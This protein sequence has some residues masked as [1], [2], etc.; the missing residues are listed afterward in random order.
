MRR[1][2][3]A[4]ALLVGLAICI[5]CMGCST[6][7]K[8]FDRACVEGRLSAAQAEAINAQDWEKCPKYRNGV[9]LAARDD[10]VIRRECSELLRD[11]TYGEDK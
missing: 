3:T 8:E 1:R 11:L 10:R 2:L 5:A 4:C 7:A 9:C 6:M